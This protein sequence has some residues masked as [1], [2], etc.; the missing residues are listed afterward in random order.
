[1]QRDG[2]WYGLDIHRRLPVDQWREALAKV[3]E[4][5]RKE[6]AAYLVDIHQRMQVAK[7]AR[8]G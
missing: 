5:H 3:P 6:A 1:M 7:R 8:H 4:E 2:L